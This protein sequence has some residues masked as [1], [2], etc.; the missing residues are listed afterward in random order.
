MF[1][2]IFDLI[3]PAA[4]NSEYLKE[5]RSGLVSGNT[6]AVKEALSKSVTAEEAARRDI[7]CGWAIDRLLLGMFIAIAGAPLPALI[8]GKIDLFGLVFCNVFAAVT[9]CISFSAAFLL[10][11]RAFLLLSGDG[12]SKKLDRIFHYDQKQ[13]NALL[14]SL[15]EAAGGDE[16]LEALNEMLVS[17]QSDLKS[18]LDAATRKFRAA[19][20]ARVIK[21][22]SY[23]S[24]LQCSPKLDQLRH[25]ARESLCA[26]ERFFY[27]R[28]IY[29]NSSSANSAC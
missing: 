3:L 6:S 27:W 28:D 21:I 25:P 11:W 20:Q 1:N 15:N 16:D 18:F 12:L 8:V 13:I 19:D 17:H 10:K 29:Q 9:M 23:I 22:L 24:T 7:Y 5:L 26:L 4:G 2:K 14:S